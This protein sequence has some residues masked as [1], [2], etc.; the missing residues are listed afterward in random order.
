MQFEHL[1]RRKLEKNTY[2]I[3]SAYND[4][5]KEVNA[6]IRNVLNGIVKIILT[7]CSGA[8][9]VFLSLLL[10]IEDKNKITE[11]TNKGY[12]NAVI[13]IFMFS[14]IL[15]ITLLGVEQLAIK[16]TLANMELAIQNDIDDPNEIFNI[17]DCIFYILEFFIIT[18][19]IL[20]SLLMAY[21]YSVLFNIDL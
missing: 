12:I 11:L 8:L 14:I 6:G 2:D 20:G 21:C 5:V 10:N 9:T 19:T 17:W 16:Q 4:T 7:Y 3:Q 13:L 15:T 1:K 18:L